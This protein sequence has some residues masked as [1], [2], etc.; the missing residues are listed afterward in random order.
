MFNYHVSFLSPWYLW[1][2][3]FL[4]LLWVMS[5]GSLAGLG[6]WRRAI[7]LLLRTSLFTLVIFALAEIHL[8]RT[9]DRLTTLFLLD[10]SSSIP[11]QQRQAMLDYASRAVKQHRRAG[12]RAGVIVFGKTAGV[13]APPFDEEL[14][15][16]STPE[17]QVD[18]TETNLAE[19][20]ELALLTF[21]SETSRRIVLV[22]DGNQ[23]RGEAREL[24]RL[25][26]ETGVGLDVVPVNYQFPGEVLVES[27]QLPPDVRKGQPFELRVVLRNTSQ[28]DVPGKLRVFQIVN[29]EKRDIFENRS[30]QERDAAERVVVSPGLNAPKTYQLNIDQ[31]NFYKY[32]A[33]F[34]PDDP[35]LDSVLANNQGSVFTHVAGS[36]R[37]LI[38][39]NDEVAYRGEHQSFANRL[40]QENIEVTVLPASQAFASLAELQQ[41]DSVILADVPRYQ[42]SDARIRML[43]QNTHDTGGGLIMLGGAHSFG[44]GGWAGSELEKAMP[45]NF[46]LKNKKVMATG[47]LA[48]VIDRSGSMS[49]RKL[50][51][52]KAAAKAAV[53]IL[54][55]R[56][57]V[58]VV[59]FDS[60]AHPIV[61]ITRVGQGLGI[62]R[63]V[64]RIQEGGGTNM[65][66]GMALGYRYLRNPS[67]S[68]AS[69][70]HMIVLTDG[71]TPPD[72]HDRLARQMFNA[73]Q[74]TTT[75]IA[76]GDGSDDRLLQ[77]VA[78]AGHG[79]FYKVLDPN[80]LPRIFT[81][82]A[83]TVTRSSI[84]RNDNGVTLQVVG[85]H[86]ALLGISGSLPPIT[87]YVM[88]T[89]KSS[90]LA[91]NG[92]AI[93]S[94]EPAGDS[95]PENRTILASWKFGVGTAVVFT[96]DVGQRWGQAWNL[97]GNYNK[98]FSQLI[99]ST[100]RPPGNTGQY[101]VDT[102]VEN[103]R[104]KL[105]VTALGEDDE[106]LNFQTMAATVARPG[107]GR[108]ELVPIRQE[109][110]GRYVGS[111][112]A[113]GLGTYMVTI[114]PGL[115]Q[116]PIRVG[117]DIPYSDEFRQ[118]QTR[119]S[120]LREL[121]SLKPADG[122]PGVVL[123]SSALDPTFDPAEMSAKEQPFR[124][125]LTKARSSQPA[126]YWATLVAC[127]LFFAD[128]GNRR[129]AMS[130]G[131]LPPL[132]ASV[133][134]RLLGQKAP[135][136]ADEYLERLKARKA[137]ATEQFGP[138][139]QVA[140]S[141]FDGSSAG[142]DGSPSLEEMTATGAGATVQPAKGSPV[143]AGP[144]PQREAET[145]AERLLRAKRKAQQDTHR[146]SH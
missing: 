143:V 52:C 121:A 112:Q 41:Y 5:F 138:A 123:N 128:V 124:H 15:L 12:D 96:T 33:R 58:A 3:V 32:E 113:D 75:T 11:L 57:F 20:I 39:E 50:Q 132:V 63:Q 118:R 101:L 48:L 60:T 122:E 7:A 81:K 90:A 29:G 140:A 9:S 4:P 146:H 53:E 134:S 27:V 55:P 17:V 108:S 115:D 6:P 1:L 86:P 67:V 88:T 119:M 46:N 111:F 54:S 68:T 99:R 97:W 117:V 76:V 23:T 69:I 106:F 18:P 62:I 126:W 10:Q 136:K 59:A 92:V 43:V 44:S 77:A 26:A 70:R 72:N 127:V 51:M 105:I 38:I 45:V 47:A 142:A 30:E 31:P 116:S 35:A 73:H 93:I 36:A 110:P 56:D 49:G 87:G 8:V 129:V 71:Q 125:N 16:E 85:S 40:R 102:H 19:A 131:W 80:T 135:A 14:R 2:L 130:F 104:V 133:S 91:R 64:G 37:V 22:T 120:L 34:E 139:R 66:P 145:Y 89:L 65:S 84:Y 98:F 61:P 13:E 114:L 25:A 95:T 107:A 74:V 83:E 94:P 141:R 109:G 79:K 137:E 144:S 28:Q 21:P 42:I 100:M 103:G 82:E 78:T 24:A